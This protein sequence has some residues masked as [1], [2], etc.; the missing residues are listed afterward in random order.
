MPYGTY[1]STKIHL[2]FSKLVS[3]TSN[4]ALRASS[5]YNVSDFISDS[6][7]CVSSDLIWASILSKFLFLAM[8]H[9]YS[10]TIFFQVWSY[11]ADLYSKV[12][13]SPLLCWLISLR[14]MFEFLLPFALRLCF[15]ISDWLSRMWKHPSYIMTFLFNDASGFPRFQ[16]RL[17]IFGLCFLS[18]FR[19]FFFLSLLGSRPFILRNAF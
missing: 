3:S 2:K 18:V 12:F 1:N 9:G 16:V 8:P 17:S 4:A 10:S 13:R 15:P 11:K 6:S 7:K 14:G 19:S 5:Y